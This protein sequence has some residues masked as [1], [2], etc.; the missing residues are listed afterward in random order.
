MRIRITFSKQGALRYTGHLDLHKIWE[1]SARRAGLTLA[2]SQGFHPH[3]KIQIAAALP[4]GIV[5][6]A[7]L[8]DMW[9]E[10][11][12]DLAALPE[13]L[14]AALPG[15]I[16]VLDVTPIDLSVPPLQTQINEA[17]YLATP[18]DELP[19]DQWAQLRAAVD[20]LMASPSLVRER[21][22]KTYDLRPLIAELR[23]DEGR[24]YLRVASREGATG[25]PEEVLAALG[26]AA[27]DFRLERTRLLFL[28]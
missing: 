16:K 9:L 27:E 3:P 2:Y 17:E 13:Q 6:H 14:Q 1:R 11:D 8:V 5:G 25:R 12:P 21:R 7:E 22:G 19:V 24:V 20:A 23:V 28:S 4:L 26:Y 15:G 10:G 18:L